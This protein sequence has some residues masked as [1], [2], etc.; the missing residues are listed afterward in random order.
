MHSQHLEFVR[1]TDEVSNLATRGKLE[2]FG[3][4]FNAP[5]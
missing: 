5:N 4:K 2:V 3:Y 1:D